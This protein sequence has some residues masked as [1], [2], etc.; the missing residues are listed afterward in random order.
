MSTIQNLP[1]L[2]VTQILKNLSDDTYEI[3]GLPNILPFLAVCRQWRYLGLPV[4]YKTMY[5]EPDYQW[6]NSQNG[7]FCRAS[8]NT[9]LL[10]D[11]KHRELVKELKIVWE[12]NDI[13]ENINSL[14]DTLGMGITKWPQ[15][16]EKHLVYDTR[17]VQDPSNEDFKTYKLNDWL[18]GEMSLIIENFKMTFPNIQSL[19]IELTGGSGVATQFTT[20]LVEVYFDQ[21]TKLYHNVYSHLELPNFPPNLTHLS[22]KCQPLSFLP[23]PKINTEPLKVLIWHDFPNNFSWKNTCNS[24]VFPQLKRLEAKSADKDS[25]AVLEERAQVLG[26]QLEPPVSQPE[27]LV[28]PVVDSLCID[29]WGV[30]DACLHVTKISQQLSY[31]NFVGRVDKLECFSRLPLKSIDYI[32]IDLDTE[33]KDM[34]EFYRITNSLFGKS[35]NNSGDCFFVYDRGDLAVDFNMLKWENVN[36]LQMEC[37]STTALIKTITAMPQLEKVRVTYLDHIDEDVDWDLLC[38]SN[39]RNLMVVASRFDGSYEKPTE[40]MLQ[41]CKSLKHLEEAS[42]SEKIYDDFVKMLDMAKKEHKHLQNINAFLH[43]Y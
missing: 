20:K 15:N 24:L 9:A 34:S 43:H 33:I 1:N 2:A 8:S 32:S 26:I 14:M 28:L 42:V 35:I 10:V 31:F 21:L 29:Y 17:F 12:S 27:E 25:Q 41:L 5:I 19:T 30:R 11:D 7:Y 22:Y 3:S 6:D 40:F 39:I 4:I 13:I 38:S 23:I 36:N 16:I 18:F 37:L